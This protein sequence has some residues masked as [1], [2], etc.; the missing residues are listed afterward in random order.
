MKKMLCFLL[1]VLM[2]LSMAACTSPEQG[3]ADTGTKPAEPVRPDLGEFSPWLLTLEYEDD[4]SKF[5]E[6][7]YDQ[8]GVLTGYGSHRASTSGN[9]LGGKT[10]KLVSYDQDGKVSNTLSKYEYVYD[11]KG[12]LVQY[13]RLEALGDKLADSFNFTYD[14]QGRLI[15][16][17]KFYMDLPQETATYT[18]DQ[19]NLVGATYQTSVYDASYTYTYGQEKWPQTVE[20]TIRYLKTENVE[21]GK[22]LVRSQVKHDA[23]L[24]RLTLTVGEGSE[25]APAGKELLM[26]EELIDTAG[27]ADA[28]RIVVGDWGGFHM[29]WL[30]MQ[31][32]GA[33]NAVNW[34]VSGGTYVFKPLAVYLTQ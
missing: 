25:G 4:T 24:Y 3:G 32:L 34:S 12:N 15:R 6:Y 7:T 8:N 17:E 1:A 30:P 2:L 11:A 9:D 27:D 10:V 18:Y 33:M 26:Y 5:R 16:Q 29:G 23:F 20:Y 31:Q 22:V 14:E 19:E 21:Q 28:V 13:R